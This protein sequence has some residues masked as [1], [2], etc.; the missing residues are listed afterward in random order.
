MPGPIWARAF[1]RVIPDTTAVP[2]LAQLL[3][4]AVLI[5]LVLL[6]MRNNFRI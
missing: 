2:G 1:P 6:A 4:S 5:F 3:I